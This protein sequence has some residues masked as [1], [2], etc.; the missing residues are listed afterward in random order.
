MNKFSKG[1][2]VKIKRG[3]ERTPVII[4][5]AMRLDHP[6]TITAVFYDKGTQHNRYYLGS[7]KQG[8]I[9]ISSIPFRASQLIL[10]R[11][12]IQGRKRDKRRYKKRLS[13]SQGIFV[14]K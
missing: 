1:D 13:D 9:D 14:R 5:E 8:D 6:R 3:N 4:R 2:K 11:K 10:W 7:N 12:G